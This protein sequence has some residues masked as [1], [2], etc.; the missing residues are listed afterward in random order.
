MPQ[1]DERGSRELNLDRTRRLPHCAPNI[2]ISGQ[3]LRNF[4]STFFEKHDPELHRTVPTPSALPHPDPRWSSSL[5]QWMRLE[6]RCRRPRATRGSPAQGA[7]GRPTKG[8]AP[9]QA[10]A[11]GQREQ[12][13]RRRAQAP[14]C[15][16]AHRL[17]TPGHAL[18]PEARLERLPAAARASPLSHDGSSRGHRGPQGS[19]SA[20]GAVFTLG[21]RESPFCWG[22]FSTF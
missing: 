22:L 6:P 11:R 20:D 8:A 18:L 7:R 4:K 21:T 10:Q 16:Q 14:A 19:S 13:G 12:P 17:G 2:N 9:H 5:E 15:P 3:K 1:E